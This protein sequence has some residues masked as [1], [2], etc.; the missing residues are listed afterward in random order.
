M[1]ERLFQVARADHRKS[2]AKDVLF[3]A[4]FVVK[5]KWAQ[6]GDWYPITAMG[7]GNPRSRD[8]RRMDNIVGIAGNRQGVGAPHLPGSGVLPQQSE[9]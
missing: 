8:H 3:T 9:A 2:A 7:Y 4:R 5:Y 1:E 6:V